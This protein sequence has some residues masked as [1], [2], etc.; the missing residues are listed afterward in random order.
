[1]SLMHI[2]V[3]IHLKQMTFIFYTLYKFCDR[4]S[5]DIL[6]KNP[7]TGVS[8]SVGLAA[9]G[10]CL[11]VGT[12]AVICKQTNCLGTDYLLYSIAASY[13]QIVPRFVRL[14]ASRLVVF[15]EFS[16]SRHVR[17]NWVRKSSAIQ[18]VKTNIKLFII[19]KYTK[20][21]RSFTHQP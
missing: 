15:R 2:V 5:S 13:I 19:N 3:C 10:L 6:S 16:E 1:M 9:P 4:N 14:R 20:L 21:D 17:N 8:A 12:S 11:E 18:P 7:W